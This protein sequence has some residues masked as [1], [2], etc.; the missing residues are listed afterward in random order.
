MPVLPAHLGPAILIGSLAGRKLNIK[1]LILSMII[2]D[3]EVL[4]LGIQTGSFNRH[5][6]LH[7]F[8]GATIFG[9]IFGTLYFIILLFLWKKNDWYYSEVKMYR[10]FKKKRDHDWM[11]SIKCTLMSAVLGAYSNIALD[12]LLYENIKVWPSP[13]P[14]IYYEFTQHHFVPTFYIIYLFCFI[15]FFMGVGLY[16]YRFYFD[17]NKEYKVSSI[18]DIRIHKKDIWTILGLISTPFAIA[19]INILFIIRTTH[20]PLFI[21]SVV[22]ILTMSIGYF[23]S[24]KNVQWKLIE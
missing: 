8:V 9:L 16:L 20:D 1:V 2:I 13:N 3:L 18:Y 7:T 6:F 15:T 23:I 11:L 19:G 12:W 22:S 21:I 10:L 24:L 17:I 5:G 14:N 4:I